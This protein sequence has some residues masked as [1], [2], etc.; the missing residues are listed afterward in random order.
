M[1]GHKT[2]SLVLVCLIFAANLHLSDAQIGVCY[3]ARGDN[4]PAPKDV[5]GL[6]T[7]NKISKLRLK[8]PNNIVLEGL[9][10]TNIEVLL[11]MPKIELIPMN[12]NYPLAEKW[13]A[14]NVKPY[15][16]DVK[17]KSI[18][19]GTDVSSNN[20]NSAVTFVF[21]NVTRPI[22]KALDKFGIKDIKLTTALDPS[23]FMD[24]GGNP[25]PSTEQLLPETEVFLV[26]NHTL[27]HLKQ[28][29]APLLVNIYPYFEHAKRQSEITPAFAL[30]TSKG[31]VL[32]DGKLK[33]QN[34]FDAMLDSFYTTLEKLGF[35]EIEIIVGQTGWPSAGGVGATLENEKTYI[36]NLI[37]HVK[38]GTPKRPNKAIQVYLDLFD[39][40]RYGPQVER[41]LGL[42]TADSKI[43]FPVS[44]NPS[45]ITFSPSA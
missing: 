18:V 43:K 45:S 3:G 38:K 5:V 16:P 40:N 2:I 30:F 27:S 20:D 32:T 17:I 23:V 34:K 41:H 6:L 37:E 39:E 11:D 35:P 44:F 42:F 1:A 8:E 4:L 28:T 21:L 10:G 14:T 31:N 26:K 12:D 13:V 33:Y 19:L 25:A 36:T 7:S 9:R 15:V 29:G 22:Q 24:L